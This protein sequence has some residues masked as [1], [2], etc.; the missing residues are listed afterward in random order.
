M[1]NNFFL[2]KNSTQLSSKKRVLDCPFLASDESGGKSSFIVLCACTVVRHS[3]S[4]ADVC[5]GHLN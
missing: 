2:L 1:H 3:P 4:I 5:R